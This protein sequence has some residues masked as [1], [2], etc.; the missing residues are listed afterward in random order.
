MDL[1]LVFVTFQK[2][3]FGCEGGHPSTRSVLQ[4]HAVLHW[5]RLLFGRL[6]DRCGASLG[7]VVRRWRRPSRTRSV[8]QGNA[9]LH[10]GGYFFGRVAGGLE[11]NFVTFQ[12]AT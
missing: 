5:R 2:A 3:T 11:L 10:W 8:L 7:N 12:K 4:G 9:V 6:A 1:E